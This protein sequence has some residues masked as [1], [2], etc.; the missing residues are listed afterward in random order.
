MLHIVRRSLKSH[1]VNVKHVSYNNY[2]AKSN[3]VL[4]IADRKSLAHSV[5]ELH[6]HVTLNRGCRDDFKMW[7]E[8]LDQWN[9]MSFFI[10]DNI[11]TAADFNLYTDASSTIGFGGYFR[12]KHMRRSRNTYNKSLIRLNLS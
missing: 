8:F 10:D 12:N 2:S 11:V 1:Q 3:K 6:Y 4:Q 9:G 5:K 7:Y